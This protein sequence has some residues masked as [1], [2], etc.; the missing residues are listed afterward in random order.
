MRNV[1]VTGCNRGLGL[2][3]AKKFHE[4][5]FN[6]I[7]INKT[8]TNNPFFDEYIC[9]ISDVNLLE[10]I[11]LTIEKKYPNIH[12]L[13]NNAGVRCLKSVDSFNI[14]EWKKSI[15]TNLTAPFYLTQ[16]A[17]P[18][19]RKTKG[20]IFFI[21]SNAGTI[22]FEKGSAY[23]VSKSALN[24]LSE[25]VFMENRVYDVKVTLI[26]PGAINNKKE[27][28][29]WK[30]NPGKIGQI[31]VDS[32]KNADNNV[33]YSVVQ[34]NPQHPLKHDFDGIELLQYF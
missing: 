8:I 21:G 22:A 29:S 15:D 32:T 33:N 1:I 17:L 30:I 4:G 7:G 19:I 25:I 11:Y 5:G 3:I 9:D 24:M 34:L 27:K 16:L 20:F 28:N 18:K 13:V 31:I 23:C 26:V 14:V 12:A 10:K 6:V 2:S